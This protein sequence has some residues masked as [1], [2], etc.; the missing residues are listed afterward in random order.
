M[1]CSE[2]CL[3]VASK[4]VVETRAVAYSGVLVEEGRAQAQGER[5]QWQPWDR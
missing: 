1:E 5:A 4:A 2:T 3:V